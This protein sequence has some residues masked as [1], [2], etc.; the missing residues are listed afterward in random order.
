MKDLLA[1]YKYRGH[2]KLEPVVAAMLAF[3]YEQLF[4]E[5]PNE[6]RGQPFFHVVSAV[7]LAPERL[8]DRGFNQ[9]ERIAVQLCNWYGLHYQSMLTRNRHTE[10]QSLKS[11]KN[12]ISDMRGNF[13][14]IDESV[15]D[16]SENVNAD[17]R[18]ILLV[19]DI[20]TTG[21]TV[22][23]CARVLRASEDSSDKTHVYGLLWARS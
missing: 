15:T 9:A 5:L 20:Y 1:L 18:R 3:A 14:L 4:D 12:R 8:A 7:P 11:R 23:E 10:K 17:P 22:N 6:T 21:S 16:A 19:D 2:E 13:S